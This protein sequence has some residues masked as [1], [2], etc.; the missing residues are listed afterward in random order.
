MTV[1]KRA[2]LNVSNPIEIKVN[3]ICNFAPRIRS[4]F[5]RNLRDEWSSHIL[6]PNPLEELQIGMDVLDS[7]GQ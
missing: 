6:K 4:L 1:V 2:A 7:N 3:A 5:L